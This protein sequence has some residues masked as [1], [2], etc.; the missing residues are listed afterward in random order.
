MDAYRWMPPAL[1]TAA[2]TT[3]ARENGVQMGN[4]LVTVTFSAVG[5]PIG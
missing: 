3:L 5:C 4:G 2:A 1:I